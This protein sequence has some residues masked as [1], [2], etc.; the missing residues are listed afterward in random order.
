[1][2]KQG[3]HRIASSLGVLAAACVAMLMLTIIVDTTSRFLFATPLPGA[4]D[5][6]RYW[7]MILIVFS[8]L[9]VAE[10]RN[11]HIEALVL[12]TTM[13]PKLRVIWRYI[14]AA[15]ITAAL[16]L[17]L[18]AT[19]PAAMKHQAQGE[20]AAG[21]EIIIWPTRYILVIGLVVYLLTVIVKVFEDRRRILRLAFEEE[22]GGIKS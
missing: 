4:N 18:I 14:R 21:S 12:E 11:E 17:L 6:N 22:E 8:A 15:T 19:I 13:P 9:G 20:Y 16:S 3:T 7:W 10:S 2:I 1:M 5:F